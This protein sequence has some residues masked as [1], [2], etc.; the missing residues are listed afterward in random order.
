ML[1]TGPTDP[2]SGILGTPATR[3]G[4]AIEHYRND[5]RNGVA[6]DHEVDIATRQAEYEVFHPGY[7]ISGLP[8]AITSIQVGMDYL[9]E[10]SDVHCG[11]AFL[12]VIDRKGKFDQVTGR[13]GGFNLRISAGE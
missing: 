3:L 5:T 10:H 13:T 1:D 6:F 7:S 2:T 9:D 8:A 12:E 11:F 4:K